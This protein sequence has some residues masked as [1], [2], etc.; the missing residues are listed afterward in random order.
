MPALVS[1]G[2]GC[3]TRTVNVVWWEQS[4]IEYKKRF[5]S[6]DNSYNSRPLYIKINFRNSGCGLRDENFL[7]QFLMRQIQSQVA[8]VFR[9]ALEKVLVPAGLTVPEVSIVP[10][11][12]QF[13][14]YQCNNAMALFKSAG[15]ELSAKSP[16]DV[17]VKIS[18]AMQPWDSVFE[19]VVVA[20][21]G[22]ITVKLSKSWVKSSLASSVLSSKGVVFED[23]NPKKRVTVDFSSPNIAKEMHVGHMRSTILGETICRMLEFAGHTTFRLNHVGDWGTQFGMLIEYIKEE[24]PDFLEKTPE[25]SDLEAFYKAAK[26]RFD[27]DADF[28]L[29]AQKR[30]VALQSGEEFARTAWKILCDISR[31][32]FQ[33]IY[34][35][36]GITIEERGES[37]YNEMIPEIVSKLSKQGLVVDSDGAKCIFTSIDDVPLMAVKSDGGFGYDSTDLAAIYHRIFEM[38]SDWIIYLTD[39]GQENHFLKIFDAARKA[40]WCS[41]ESCRLDHVGFGMVLGEDGKRFRTRSS[42]TVKLKDLLDE[43]QTRSLAELKQRQGT[44]DVSEEMRIASETIGIAAVRYFDMRNNRTTNYVFDYDK[45]LDPKGNTAVY[46]LYAYARIC[47]I[48]R[49]SGVN[50]DTI[51]VDTELSLGHETERMLALELLKFPDMIAS[52]LND[53]LPHKLTDYM[54][55]LSNKFTAFYMECR[56]V[57]SPEM[58]SRLLLCK[59]TKEVLAKC[60]FFLGIKPL[61]QM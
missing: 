56:V 20:P 22:F 54:W 36:L 9:A 34:D 52:V 49:Q 14:D 28:K 4:I 60:F 16:R 8:G 31:K 43:A 42:E 24:Y 12:P 3:K 38:Q 25:I 17:A 40:G 30:V 7:H 55:D 50:L 18:E 41:P 46:L 13:G 32:S 23:P 26:R 11:K 29:R 33:E 61:E 21:A 35:R 53:L 51:D 39:L 57:D 10:S 5:F 48:M 58:K 45:M 2:E 27:A 15:K 44:E 47:S 59:A 1:G 19:S 6:L 37:F